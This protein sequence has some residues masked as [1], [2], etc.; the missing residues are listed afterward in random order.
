ME[1]EIKEKKSRL[2]TD[3]QVVEI[4]ITRFWSD[5]IRKL[6]NKIFCVSM[7]DK[8]VVTYCAEIIPSYELTP[9][10]YSVDFGDKEYTDEK[11]EEIQEAIDREFS[12]EEIEYYHCGSLDNNTHADLKRYK[13]NKRIT[14]RS[15]EFYK[16]FMEEKE[17]YFKCNHVI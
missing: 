14:G 17:E 4:D 9:L 10:Y 2:K 15:S 13:I 7:Y 12:S 3:I 8:S 1:T 11:K 16:S 5:E 6:V